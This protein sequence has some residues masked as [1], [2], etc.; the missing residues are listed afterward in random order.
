MEGRREGRKA[1][2]RKNCQLQSESARAGLC[3]RQE[4]HFQSSVFHYFSHSQSQ[5]L[6]KSAAMC[7]R[8]FLNVCASNLKNVSVLAHRRVA[9]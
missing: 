6:Q 9:A 1:G 8:E 2:R 4:G 5:R 3:T 7:S